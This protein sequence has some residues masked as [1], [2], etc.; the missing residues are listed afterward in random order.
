MRAKMIK[1]FSRIE[2]DQPMKSG[3][4]IGKGIC[5][6]TLLLLSLFLLTMSASSVAWAAT[7]TVNSTADEVDANPGDGMCATAGGV[8]TLRAAVQEANGWTGA[9]TIDVPAGNYTFTRTGTGEDNAATGDLD[10]RENL[11][12]TG[13]GSSSTIIDAAG[14]DRV[15][16]VMNGISASLTGL[17]IWNGNVSDSG[18]GIQYN[19]SLTLTDVI[20]TNNT[21]IKNGGGIICNGDSCALY[22][23]NANINSNSASNGAGVWLKDT[24]GAVSLTNVTI[25]G[26]QAVKEGGGLCFEGVSGLIIMTGVTV[27]GNSASNGGGIHF[28][29]CGTSNLTNVTVS[30]NQAVKEG[31]GIY[32][33]ATSLTLTNV[34]IT[35][36]TGDVAKGG[37]LYQKSGSAILKNTIIAN[38]T[39]GGDCA[40]SPISADHNLD[41]DGTCGCT[42]TA[43]PLLGPLQDNGGLTFTHALLAGSPA[44][45]A[46]T[47]TG[48]PATDQRGSPRPIDGDGDLTATADIGAYEAELLILP[49][50]IMVKSV[51]TFSDPYNGET[52]PK[53]IPGAAMLYT[54]AATNQG[55]GTADTDTVLITD[56]IST[57]TALFVG[58]INGSGSGPVLFTDG[59]TASGLSYT[60]TSLNSTTDDVDFSNDGGTTYTYVPVPDADGFDANVTHMRVTPKGTFNAASGGD[61]PSF[62]VKFK[63][64]VK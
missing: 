31:G 40:G 59:A 58:D 53:A 13:A 55:A 20:V 54:V 35:G 32:N 29:A 48:A 36:N 11:N 16:D 34:T 43:D 2:S 23:T 9:D 14:L 39:T 45:D 22:L 5:I 52:N 49:D 64:K 37:G 57:N 15:F 44:I 3:A 38:S 1:S 41:S 4:V 42:L 27:N 25:S 56:P 30:G 50:I 46:G 18:A 6:G 12:I 10:I 33:E 47:N 60:F 63:V 7:F 17:T 28:K 62:E 19:T 24:T 8:C 51:Q 61:I 21:S 26:N